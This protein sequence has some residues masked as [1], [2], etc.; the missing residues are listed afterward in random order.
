MDRLI[1]YLSMDG[2]WPFIWPAY[3]FAAVV[4]IV[5]LVVSLRTLHANERAAAAAESTRARRGRR[6]GTDAPDDA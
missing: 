6:R 4:L 1:D 3:G 2:Y 5:L